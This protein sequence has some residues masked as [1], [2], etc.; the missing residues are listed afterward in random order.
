MSLANIK[1]QT[2]S[3][4]F[5]RTR[6]TVARFV[7]LDDSTGLWA[8]YGLSGPGCIAII[9]KNGTVVNPDATIAGIEKYLA[10][11]FD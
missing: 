3:L 5:L 7:E 11:R 4:R 9:D 2:I 8:K 6:N 10:E 1:I